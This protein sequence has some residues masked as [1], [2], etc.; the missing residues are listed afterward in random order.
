MLYVPG[1][2]TKALAKVPTLH[3]DAVILDLE[4]AVSPFSKESARN[5][6]MIADMAVL[7]DVGL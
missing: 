5:N 1:S 7:F 6:V 4:D 2:N 3:S